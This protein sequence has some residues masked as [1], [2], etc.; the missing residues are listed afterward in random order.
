ML[1]RLRRIEQARLPGRSPFEVAHGS[2]DAWE[3][4]C[5]AGVDGGDFD[6][7]DMP[8]VVQAVR[9]WHQAGLYH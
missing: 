2:L 6:P 4:E 5:R 8:D 9:G 7:S 3:A 1:S